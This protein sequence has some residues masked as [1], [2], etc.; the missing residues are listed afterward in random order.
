MKEIVVVFVKYYVFLMFSL[1]LDCIFLKEIILLRVF[2]FR[3]L[4]VK[5]NIIVINVL[6]LKNV[7]VLFYC[8]CIKELDGNLIWF[9]VVFEG[10]EERIKS[11][12]DK[13]LVLKNIF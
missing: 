2:L 6:F 13:L 12:G 9:D 4:E 7:V 10:K 5:F 1:E 11:L 8:L 3:N